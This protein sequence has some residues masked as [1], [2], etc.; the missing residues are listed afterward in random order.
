MFLPCRSCLFCFVLFFGAAA[1]ACGILVPQPG[2]KPLPSVVEARNP[3]HWISRE[4]PESFK[5]LCSPIFL[6]HSPS[7][8]WIF[9]SRFGNVL[10]TPWLWRYTHLFSSDRVSH[11]HSSVSGFLSLFLQ[12][13]SS[14]VFCEVR[15]QFSF[16]MFISSYVNT[17]HLKA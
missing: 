1:T 11:F 8:L 15:F 6:P 13:I 9:E 17:A 3:N 2:I 16:S 5:F 7:C 12:Y 14:G 4:F 10:F